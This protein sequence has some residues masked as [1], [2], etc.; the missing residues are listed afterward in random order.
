LLT[1]RQT[2]S[3]RSI[4]SV[5][6]KQVRYR[7]AEAGVGKLGKGGELPEDDAKGPQIALRCS[8]GGRRRRR[9]EEEEEEG[10]EGGIR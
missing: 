7:I 5:E 10:G 1:I 3:Q 8:E 9:R 2:S 6:R 4:E